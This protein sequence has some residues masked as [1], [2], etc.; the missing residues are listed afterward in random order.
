MREVEMV[1]LITKKMD[2][3]G[4]FFVNILLPVNF[5]YTVLY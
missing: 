2:R 3:L 4:S 5:Q 1:Q